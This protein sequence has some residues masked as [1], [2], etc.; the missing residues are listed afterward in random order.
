MGKEGARVKKQEQWEIGKMDEIKLFIKIGSQKNI[1][2]F[3]AN[4]T[5]YLNT[6]QYFR[7]IE[8]EELRGDRYEGASRIVNSLPGTFRIPGIDKDFHFEKVHYTEAFDTVLGNIFSLYCVSPL[9]FP[10]PYDFKVDER[11]F[12]FGSHCVLIK[13]NQR[14][15][16]LIKQAFERNGYAYTYGFVK[17]YDKENTSKQLTVFDKPEEFEY[18]KEFRFYVKNDEVS[19]IK[20]QLGSLKE[21]AEIFKSQQLKTLR[22]T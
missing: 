14:F 6:V 15:L 21:Y 16:E 2:D 17:Y 22:L 8:D 1:E 20:L 19:P 4:G 18:Q 9:G 11:N 7:E 5:I 10:N 3:Y 13:D 12:R